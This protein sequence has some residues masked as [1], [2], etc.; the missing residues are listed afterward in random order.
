LLQKPGV[1]A[2]IV[3]ISKPRQLEE[4]IGALEVRL[5]PEEIVQLEE[6]YV[7]HQV[8]GIL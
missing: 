8:A 1:V 3:G 6:L 7:P 2:P 5:N 4:A